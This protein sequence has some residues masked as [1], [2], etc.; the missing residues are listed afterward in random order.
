[1]ALN[2]LYGNYSMPLR[3]VVLDTGFSHPENFV[4]RSSRKGEVTH[5]DDPEGSW[6]NAGAGGESNTIDLKL[7]LQDANGCR[8]EKCDI[9]PLKV[10][11]WACE[12]GYVVGD[13]LDEVSQEL[14]PDKSGHRRSKLFMVSGKGSSELHLQHNGVAFV[15]IRITTTSQ[16]NERRRFTIEV[17]PDL[18]PRQPCSPKLGILFAGTAMS[19]KAGDTTL[20]NKSLSKPIEVMSKINKLAKKREAHS[21]VHQA[22]VHLEK[23][24]KLL[25][26]GRQAPNNKGV[27]ELLRMCQHIRDVLFKGKH[28]KMDNQ[29]DIPQD[30]IEDL[31]KPLDHSTNDVGILDLAQAEESQFDEMVINFLTDTSVVDCL[32]THRNMYVTLDHQVPGTGK[33]TRG[34][35]PFGQYSNQTN[36]EVASQPKSESS[37]P[38]PPSPAASVASEHHYQ[39]LKIPFT[40]HAAQDIVGTAEAVMSPGGHHHF[41]PKTFINTLHER[42]DKLKLLF[43]SI[44]ANKDGFISYDELLAARDADILKGSDEDIEALHRWMDTRRCDSLVDFEEFKLAMTLLPTSTTM[45]TLVKNFRV[46]EENQ[47]I[48]QSWDVNV[49]RLSSSDHFD[50]PNKKPKTG[51]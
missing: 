10:R 1:M 8:V 17:S 7:E 5:I 18:S 40:S 3:V 14:E 24:L 21:S 15:C 43:D 46:H 45:E 13:P 44:D 42:E 39:I 31:Y 36:G 9:I 23:A 6:M 38:R 20:Y 19:C 29:D 49:K 34:I 27:P 25:Q 41:N 4:N 32:Y 30:V 35:N 12:N 22:G 47:I 26:E 11:L 37:H 50:E 16:L 33:Y 51:Y 28:P 48:K 2:E